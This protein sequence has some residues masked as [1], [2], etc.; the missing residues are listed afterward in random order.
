MIPAR[1]AAAA[2]QHRKA[3]AGHR[4]RRGLGNRH[5]RDVIAAGEG[6]VCRVRCVADLPIHVAVGGKRGALRVAREGAVDGI[7]VV[8]EEEEQ[9]S[10][11]GVR[12]GE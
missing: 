4:A 5:D 7:R 6:I 1:P 12:A 11:L 3:D 10:V 9:Q 8:V 2:Q